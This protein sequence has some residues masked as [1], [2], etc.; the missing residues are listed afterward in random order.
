MVI[1]GRMNKKAVFFTFIAVMLLALLMFSFSIYSRYSMRTRALVIE[2]RINTM[3][4]FMQDIDKDIER[5]GFIISHRSILSLVEYISS[6]GVFVDDAESSFEELFM[7]GTIDGEAQS[8]MADTTFSDWVDSMKEQ[9]NR[10]N[11]NID[12]NIES[13]TINHSNPWEV[14]VYLEVN[15]FVEDVTGIAS[16]NITK[17]IMSSI[18]IEGFE[19]PTYVVKT[20]GK[21]LNVI[22]KTPYTDFV[23]GTDTSNLQAHTTNSYYLAWSTAPS[24]LMRLEGNLNSSPYGIES[25][26]NLQKLIDQGEGI[27]SRSV[28]DHIY[29]SNKPVTSYDIDYMPSWFMIDDEYNS[30]EGMD[31]LE[32]Y[33]VDGIIS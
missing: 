16:W 2:I 25:L 9:G 8:L 23:S 3:N 30:D 15:I 13:I 7:N 32:L 11:I 17:T 1:L 18:P 33:E 14:D 20:N 24:F 29:W 26:V 12:F 21:M 4:G 6:N 27:D 28:V 5:G 31:H 10:I 22:N 19:D